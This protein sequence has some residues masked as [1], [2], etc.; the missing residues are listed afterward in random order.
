VPVK[1]RD[2]L[3]KPAPVHNRNIVTEDGRTFEI[4]NPKRGEIVLNQ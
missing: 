4:E 2:A 1:C 3:E